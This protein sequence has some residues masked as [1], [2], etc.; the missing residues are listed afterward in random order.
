MQRLLQFVTCFIIVM[1][2]RSR[3]Q[4]VKISSGFYT[5]KLF[6]RTTLYVVRTDIN[7]NYRN[8]A[9]CKNCYSVINELGIKRIIF[10]SDEE[11]FTIVKTSDYHTE[12]ISNGNRYLNMTDE[13]KSQRYRKPKSTIIKA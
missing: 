11:E 3:S 2:L 7:G 4:H 10:S 13:E 1:K 8:S 6:R 12:H 5:Q 9:P